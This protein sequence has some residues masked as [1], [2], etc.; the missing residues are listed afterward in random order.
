MKK[1]L[2]LILVTALCLSFIACPAALGQE[3][4]LSLPKGEV[5]I[6]NETV[7]VCLMDL[8]LMTADMAVQIPVAYFNETGD[9]PY[10]PIHEMIDFLNAY[11]TDSGADYAI[12]M[13]KEN[14]IVNIEKTNGC[15]IMLSKE[16]DGS[17]IVIS[18]V[19]SLFVGAESNGD[20]LT[21]GGAAEDGIYYLSH[22]GQKNNDA[23]SGY[24]LISNLEEDYG[25]E[26]FY[27]EDELFIPLAMFSD[28]FLG[29]VASMLYNGQALFLVSG[30]L[31]DTVEDESGRTLSD[32]YYSLEPGKRSAALS[33]FTY[34]ELCFVL[35]LF[36][37]LKDQHGIDSFNDYFGMTG[38]D[39]GLKSTDAAVFSTA[40]AD[41]IYNYFADVHSS[42]KYNSSF[43]GKDLMDPYMVVYDENCPVYNVY[44]RD[45][46]LMA[47]RDA[48][49]LSC[50]G[51]VLNAYEEVGNTAYITFDSFIDPVIEYY[52]L[53][54]EGTLD[55]ETL[56]Q[57]Y[58]YDT[59]G[60]VIY[61]NA[62]IN[63]E[64]S[65][66]ENV[67]IDL[68]CNGGGSSNAAAYITAW[69]LGKCSFTVRNNATS[70]TYANNYKADTDLDGTI[71]ESDALDMDR[72]DVYCLI[73]PSSFS[74]GNLVPSL[75]K[76]DG[77]VTLIGQKSAGGSCGMMDV[78]TADGTVFSISSYNEF[79]N[80]KN[81]SYYSVDEGVEP[82]IYI[83]HIEK[84]Y[85][86][87]WLTEYI[88][89]ID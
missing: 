40:L 82:D 25:I 45:A 65:P 5:I 84:L 18:D 86:R 30:G 56:S 20:L 74:C 4:T 78:S 7:T 33:D 29:N 21:I 51:T 73:S 54:T 47:K 60:L 3:E 39:A 19:G 17:W 66:I 71:T 48:A 36:Y 11:F 41:L 72:L 26:L 38:L 53:F 49:G 6:S 37:G 34:R 55:L 43:A 64:N 2:S 42:Y 69:V 35:D 88:N 24:P 1:A 9:V 80:A 32:I 75:F 59:F 50:E 83:K 63:R 28:L 46:I 14:H 15:I 44:V 12:T 52:D 8:Y 58:M 76:A 57:F 68:S 10:V 23:A 85:D 16:D 62:M 22:E 31:D 89:N 61:A 70:A 81:G 87:A 79:C 27:A 77:R 67:V 13:D